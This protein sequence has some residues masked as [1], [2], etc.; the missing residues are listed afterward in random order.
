MERLSLESLE[1]RRLRRDLAPCMIGFLLQTMLPYN[2]RPSTRECVHIVTCGH[3]RSRDKDGGHNIRS[4]VA[5]NPMLHANFMALCF[6]KPEL[7]PIEV[8]HCGNRDFQHFFCSCDLDLDPMTFIH[9]PDRILWR[10]AN[11]N[12]LRQGFR[13][14]SSDR[15]T[16]TTEIIYHSASWVVNNA[17]QTNT[18][19]NG[20][21]LPTTKG[22]MRACPPRY[23]H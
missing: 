10:C 1:L 18:R 12:L 2:L 20:K 14:L 3:F 8:L 5:E 13:K 23:V 21:N 15:Q 7:L 11:M 19:V 22:N 4:T 9:E 6:I 17:K 16:D